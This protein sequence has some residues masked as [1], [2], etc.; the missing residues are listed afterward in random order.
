M[1]VLKRGAAMV[2]AAALL[3]LGASAPAAA[4]DWAVAAEEHPV[5]EGSPVSE[6]AW[7]AARPPG[8]AFD[9]IGLHRYRA[10]GTPAATLLYLPG[11]NM[12]GALALTDEAHNLWLF[13]AARGI[14]VFALDYR[15]HAVPADAAPEALA[16]MKDWDSAAF[17]ED[18]RAA[19]AKARAESGRA[20]LFV[21]GFSR[22]AFLAYAY[23]NVEPEAVA[24]LVILDGPFKAYAPKERV[25]RAAAVAALAATGEWASD[26][27]GSHGW[28]ARQDLMRAVIT[29]P[30]GPASDAAFNTV[31][32]QL[33]HVLQTAWGPGALANPEGGVSDP[34][35]LA[36]LL[37]GYDR[38]YPAVQ[39]I[40]GKAISAEADA[41]DTA[42]DDRWGKLDIP[43][44]LFVNTGMGA[45]WV[46]T[47]LYSAAH[48]GSKDVTFTVL[49]GYGHL[50]VLVG[51]RAAT[52]V[53]EPAFAWISAR[54]Q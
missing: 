15:T 33:A 26:V 41:P 43:V 42:L 27:G 45:D 14:E 9:T 39:D 3:A 25:D 2:L 4:D 52:E 47:A 30:N 11:T 18:I 31:G 36:R 19:A 17:V 6:T 1:R 23:A 8:G 50:D 5:A 53:F 46:L 12:N 34:A 38:Y 28:E 21:A 29:D 40:D 35:V 44:L 24:G 54:A 51:E 13:L 37:V 48:A 10:S 32:A 16:A 49:E 22:G 20:K 7:T